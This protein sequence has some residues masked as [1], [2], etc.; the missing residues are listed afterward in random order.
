MN[1]RIA[2][3]GDAPR[4]FQILDEVSSEIP[5]RLD[6]DAHQARVKEIVHERIESNLSLVAT[7]GSGLILGLILIEPKDIGIIS[8]YHLYLSYICV[9]RP[10]RNQGISTH[11]IE[12]MKGCG[13]PLTATVKVR[14]N[15][16]ITDRLTDA[17]F[18]V[19][20]DNNVERSFVWYPERIPNDAV[21]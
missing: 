9:S 12:K 16:G 21:I 11:L 1:I 18:K 14:N 5:L 20:C 4:I 15:S 10:Y 17:G 19:K 8:R 13:F 2:N 6:T 7:N 3:F